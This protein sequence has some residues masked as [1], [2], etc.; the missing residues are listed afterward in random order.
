MT[1]KEKDL[2]YSGDADTP[3]RVLLTTDE[4]DSLFLR[5]KSLDIK[6]VKDN[7][8][9]QLLV[10]RMRVT[11]E[12]E[13]GVGLAAPQVGIGRNLFLFVRIDKPEYP[14]E[15]VVNPKITAHSED[16]FCFDDDGCL[17]VPDASGTSLRY[18]WIEVEYLNEQGETIKEH[19]QGGSRFEN[20]IGVIFQ[21]EYDHLQGTLFTDKLCVNEE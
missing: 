1:K 14:V 11:L 12:L 3:L 16:M 21:H 13:N 20:F 2:I 8:A 9:L 7:E 17:S 5:Q 10:Q 18:K 15:V 4:K 19:L 6:K